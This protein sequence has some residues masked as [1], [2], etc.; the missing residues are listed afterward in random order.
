MRSRFFNE[1]TTIE[2]GKYLGR[3][4]RLAL[5]PVGSVEMHGPHLPA[6]TDAL[7]AKAFSLRLAERA[8][9]LVLPELNYTWAGATD[10]FPG[11]VSIEPELVQKT[12]EAIAEKI[13][14]MGF[15]QIVLINAHSPN[16]FVLYSTVRRFFENR[17]P[18]YMIDMGK[19][20]SEEAENNIPQEASLFLAA[21]TILGLP[22]LYS[23]D[24]VVYD[25][26]APPLDESYR[27]LCR[28]GVVGYHFQDARQHVAPTRK[29]SAME[30]LAFIDLQVD[31]LLPL[32]DDL[33]LYIDAA[34]EQKNQGWWKA[35]RD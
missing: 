19:P 9:G 5:L 8:D 13:V 28:A 34:G 10:G 25:D 27:R 22:D 14:R 15:K 26:P 21:L 12:V 4:G 30:G 18:I 33:G 16:N 32:L 29:A 2:I 3:G 6:G 1:L 17:H 24:D 23:E 20:F 31:A 7:V 11:T 35:R